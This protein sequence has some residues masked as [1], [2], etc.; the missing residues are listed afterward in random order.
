MLSPV[1]TGE[2]ISL[3]AI[4]MAT[5]ST[6]TK[7]TVTVAVLVAVIVVIVAYLFYVG[8]HKQAVDICRSAWEL[9]I[10]MRD[11]SHEEWR[12]RERD[13]HVRR[14]LPMTSSQT[15]LKAAPR[16]ADTDEVGKLAPKS[17]P[18]STA[19]ATAGKPSSESSGEEQT[20][21]AMEGL[22]GAPFR[23]V[24]PPFLR[25]PITQRCLELDGYNK[26][27]K[28]AF[29]YDG[30]QH[31]CWPN[32]FHKTR[33]QFD[34]QQQRDRLKRVLCDMAGVTLITVPYTVKH[35]E[36]EPFLRARLAD[37]RKLPTTSS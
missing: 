3:Q 35:K 8:S 19:A 9:L 4:I 34:A 13:V 15:N 22:L 1:T 6:R 23:R 27:L 24:R 36:I 10:D 17:S 29:E 20:R 31:Y 21:R 33:Q 12:R 5:W 32:A 26:E 18:T 28:L 2:V 16:L 25:S 37:L 7:F 11:A 30:Q 14:R